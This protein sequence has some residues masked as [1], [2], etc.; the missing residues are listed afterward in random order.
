MA[1]TR[2]NFVNSRGIPCL[3]TVSASLTTTG[4]TYTFNSHPYIAANFQGLFAVKVSGTAAAPTDAVPIYFTTAGVG[5]ST[6][7]VFD[8]AGTAL[9]TATWPGDGVFLFWYDR[10]TNVTRLMTTIPSTT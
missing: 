8:A 2:L 5:N 1:L 6:V 9:T 10:T 7:Q 3:E 4:E